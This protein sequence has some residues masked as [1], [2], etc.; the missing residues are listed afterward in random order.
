MADWSMAHTKN[1]MA[2]S[3]VTLGGKPVIAG[4]GL[5]LLL[6]LV[7]SAQPVALETI[8]FYQR[9]LSAIAGFAGYRCRFAPTCSRSAET[10]IARDGVVRGGWQ[11]VKRIARCGPWTPEGT[12]DDP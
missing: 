3:L 10:V 9:H 1:T 8:H 2:G 5:G 6:T 7:L 4:V 11:T 12:R